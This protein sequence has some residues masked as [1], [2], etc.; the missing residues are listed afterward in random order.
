MLTVVPLAMA[1]VNVSDLLLANV[2]IANLAIGN[3]LLPEE[4]ALQLGGKRVYLTLT[5]M[6]PST[7]S[8]QGNV[9]VSYPYN[10]KL[11]VTDLQYITVLSL[12]CQECSFTVNCVF[13]VKM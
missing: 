5:L 11:L 10:A 3:S 12:Q 9:N 6:L 8:L 4:I 7:L 13:L 1:N 2:F